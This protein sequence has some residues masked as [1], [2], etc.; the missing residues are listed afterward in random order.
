MAKTPEAINPQQNIDV[1]PQVKKERNDGGRM[2]VQ[3]IIKADLD[4]EGKADNFPK[5]YQAL[6]NMLA[7]NKTRMMRA[8]N[9]L[10]PYTMIQPGVVEFHVINGDSPKNLGKN[11]KEFYDAMLK[12]NFKMG[13][14]TTENPQI[15]KLAE[16]VG[17]PVES[18]QSQ[19]FNG[20]QM[21]PTI[22]VIIRGQ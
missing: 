9:T 14:S 10:F 8:G 21:V 17:I 22:E 15:L 19:R 5:V 11:L 7:T 4:R 1:M 2:S 12:A 20:K 16:S 13:V 18:R 6:A 3:D